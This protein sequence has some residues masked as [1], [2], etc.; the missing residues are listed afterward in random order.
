MINSSKSAP[1]HFK[2]YSNN[3]ISINCN[4]ASDEIL[5]ISA[6]GLLVKI[7]ALPK[8]SRLSFSDLYRRSTNEKEKYLLVEGFRQLVEMEYLC[9]S[10]EDSLDEKKGPIGNARFAPLASYLTQNARYPGL[11]N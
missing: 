7:L 5:S 3:H 9:P 11:G 8:H 1:T 2:V 4:I 10:L 6:F